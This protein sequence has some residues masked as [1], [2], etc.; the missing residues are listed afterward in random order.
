MTAFP[1][2]R[3]AEA[4]GGLGKGVNTWWAASVPYAIIFWPNSGSLPRVHLDDRPYFG[5]I[6]HLLLARVLFFARVDAGL[7]LNDNLQ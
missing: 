7:W 1:H 4:T 6:P 2:E 3:N 5:P